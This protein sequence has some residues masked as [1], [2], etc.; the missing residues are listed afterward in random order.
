[1]ART[2]GRAA[3]P[4]PYDRAPRR[5]GGPRAGAA[6][7]PVGA[8]VVRGKPGPVPLRSGPWA[9]NRGPQH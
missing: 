8:Q 5:G 2:S 4:R 3:A 6:P 1:M 9:Q 7:D